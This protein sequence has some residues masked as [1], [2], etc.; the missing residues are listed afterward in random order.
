MKQNHKEILTMNKAKVSANKNLKKSHLLIGRSFRHVWL[1]KKQQIYFT[2]HFW[3]YNFEQ[4]RQLV[5]L[6]YNTRP[7]CDCDSV[8]HAQI[9][10]LY[11]GD[12][13]TKLHVQIKF[14]FE[15]VFQNRK[16][17]TNQIQLCFREMVLRTIFSEISLKQN[18]RIETRYQYWAGF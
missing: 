17:Y 4:L 12:S 18:H 9:E 1:P 14:M 16:K 11:S 15:E 2:S 3:F 5:F 13:E 8:Q 7:S 6:Q 10:Y